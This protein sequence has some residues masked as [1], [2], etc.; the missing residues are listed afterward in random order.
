[1]NPDPTLKALGLPLQGQADDTLE[2]VVE[3]IQLA[4]SQWDSADLDKLMNEEYRQ[5][6]TIAWTPE[7]YFSSEHG[8]Q[9]G[10]IGLYEITKEEDP[11]PQAAAWW[12]E[13]ESNPSSP[14]RPLA[15][16]K[17]VDLT[18]V[19][20]GPAITRGL[21]ELGAS[22]MR[23]TSPHHTDL[24]A[25]HHDLNWG[26][27]NA[28]LDLKVEAN[29]EKLRQLILDADVVVDGYRPGVMERLG[30]GPQAVF[31]L[32][33]GRGRGIV[34]ARENAYGWHGPW[35]HRSGWQQVSDACCGV[36]MGYG[37]AMGNDE[38]V[39]PVFPNSDYCTGVCGVAGILD[40]LVK[41]AEDGGSYKVEVSTSQRN[42]ALCRLHNSN[43]SQTALNYYS[44]WLVRSCGTYP[45][46]IWDELWK[47]HGSP[48]FRH[49][50]NMPYL[51][52]AMLKLLHQ[53]DKD[54]LFNP[55]FFEQRPSGNLGLTFVVPKPVVQ[56]PDGTVEPKYQV[57]TRGNGVDQPFWPRDLKVEVVTEDA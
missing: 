4:V 32:V 27:W 7:E 38:A 50:H 17:V 51:L 48:V 15:G 29:K 46:D 36:S 3:R 25:V 8:K 39:T 24:S 20:A 11:S 5:A 40:A 2:K 54:V 47:R 33:R 42:V 6:G 18:R 28:C 57:G 9:S 34:Y 26:K 22:V 55:S 41:R 35:S 30:F 52:P 13:H 31:D 45:E 10:R 56:F 16:L 44:Q 43:T 1:M 37:R 19:I 21:A 53:H 49:Y 23:V 12:P 14:S